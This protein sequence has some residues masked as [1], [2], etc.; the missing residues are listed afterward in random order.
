MKYF[1]T[2]LT[3]RLVFS[4]LVF[5]VVISCRTI[6][7]TVYQDKGLNFKITEEFKIVKTE[8]WKHNDATYIKIE[9]RNENLYA[10]FSVTWLPKNFDLDKELRVFEETLKEMYER[11]DTQKIPV[12][13]EVKSIKFASNEARRIDYIVANDGPRLGS[14]TAFHCDS[15]T[16]IIGQHYTPES[17]VMTDRC[18]QMIEETYSC[19]GQGTAR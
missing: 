4:G 2:L 16:V 18:R 13:G 9:R 15:L 8:T 1:P 5:L 10:N 17:Q 14:Y 12:F 3:N 6:P 11:E 7:T 19:I